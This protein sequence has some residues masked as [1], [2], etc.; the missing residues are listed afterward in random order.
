V[1][2]RDPRS[3]TAA[4]GTLADSIISWE[5]PD[6]LTACTDAQILVQATPLGM[7]P[8]ANS[9]VPLT[10]EAVMKHHVVMD[11]V[12]TP[13]QTRFLDMARGQGASCLNGWPMLVHQAAVA[14]DFWL[15]PGAGDGLVEA[16]GRFETRDP[17]EG[18]HLDN[19]K[20]RR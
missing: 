11:L 18:A 5:D 16:V 14:L 6:L 12:Y 9:C 20:G 8:H 13:W 1:V 2:T 15:K 17:S 3:R 19:K 7:T 10:P 4:L